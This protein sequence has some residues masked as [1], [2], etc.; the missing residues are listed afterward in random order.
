MYVMIPTQEQD[1]ALHA[2]IFPL[3]IRPDLRKADRRSK[4]TCLSGSNSLRL[5]GFAIALHGR[6]MVPETKAEGRRISDKERK[7]SIPIVIGGTGHR[8]SGSRT[9]SGTGEAVQGDV[10]T[11]CCLHGLLL[12]LHPEQKQKRHCPRKDPNTPR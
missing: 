7:H 6:G 11:D 12:V 8:Q 1:C 3:Q 10:P 2:E 9:G 4:H 5:S